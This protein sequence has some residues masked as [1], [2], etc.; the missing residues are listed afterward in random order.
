MATQAATIA[1]S[2]RTGKKEQPLVIGV[3]YVTQKQ[4]RREFNNI[5]KRT[6]QRWERLRMM[7]PKIRIGQG[8]YYSKADIVCWMEARKEFPQDFE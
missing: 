7:P 4:F 1:P 8:V 2:R 5:S 3:D 6:I